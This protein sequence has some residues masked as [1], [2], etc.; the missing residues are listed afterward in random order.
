MDRHHHSSS[1]S[2]IGLDSPDFALDGRDFIRNQILESGFL[3]IM[4]YATYFGLLESSDMKE[5]D[6]IHAVC[7]HWLEYDI[8][9]SHTILDDLFAL[10]VDGATAQS[11]DSKEK[12]FDSNAV[13]PVTRSQAKRESSAYRRST[14]SSAAAPTGANN[15]AR[16]TRGKSPR[17]NSS[18][19][20]RPTKRGR[21]NRR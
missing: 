2:G 4:G 9:P 8:R 21:A 7:S 1:N 12:V 13:G 6:V 11:L 5:D 19:S 3:G 17:T 16:T 14:R 15:A 10:E 18:A 20:P